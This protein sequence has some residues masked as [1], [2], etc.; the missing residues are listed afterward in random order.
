MAGAEL[1]ERLREERD[2]DISANLSALFQNLGAIGRQQY[3]LNTM[4]SNPFV[5]FQYDKNGNMIR[6]PEQDK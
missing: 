4:T 2:N 5:W 6:K 3:G 1:R